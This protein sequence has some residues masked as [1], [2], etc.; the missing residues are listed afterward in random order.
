MDI[1]NIEQGTHWKEF[2]DTHKNGY[3]HWMDTYYIQ[4]NDTRIGWIY[5]MDRG[6]HWKEFLDRPKM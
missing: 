6:T 4:I 3:E 2:L 5:N 1:C